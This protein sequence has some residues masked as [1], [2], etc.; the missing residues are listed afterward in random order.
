MSQQDWLIASRSIG[1]GFLALFAVM[2]LIER[3]LLRFAAPI[4]GASW[5]P[6]AQLALEC[7]VLAGVGWLIGRWGRLGVAI[8]AATLA[9]VN[10][11]LVP[12]I[13]FP[14]L[15]HSLLDCF[16]NTRYLEPFVTSLATHVLLFSSLF[17]G[18]HLGRAKQNRAREQA[19]LHI[20]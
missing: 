6:T 3:P 13:D 20:K 18:S 1:I 14:W 4:L 12:A 15:F 10:F 16:Q 11:C 19:A 9:L 17:V 2:F 5:L 7:L 8:F